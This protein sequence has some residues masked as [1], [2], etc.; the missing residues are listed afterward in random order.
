MEQRKPK[1]TLALV[2]LMNYMV[3]S[4]MIQPNNS[5]FEAKVKELNANSEFIIGHVLENGM[6][7]AG[8]IPDELKDVGIKASYQYSLAVKANL[9]LNTL[10]K[11]AYKVDLSQARCYKLSVP[12]LFSLS[13]EDHK[14]VLLKCSTATGDMPKPMPTMPDD[15]ESTITDF[16]RRQP[17]LEN[18]KP[19]RAKA[20]GGGSVSAST[21]MDPDILTAKVVAS[22]E[23]R[24]TRIQY[25]TRETIEIESELLKSYDVRET[26]EGNLKTIDTVEIRLNSEIT[27]NMF[28]LN[29]VDGATECRLM[30]KTDVL[31]RTMRI[32]INQELKEFDYNTIISVMNVYE[33]VGESIHILRKQNKFKKPYI[34]D[35]STYK[36]YA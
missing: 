33:D 36:V 27:E 2:G 15:P 8:D 19:V 12:E 20:T 17:S 29:F 13:E 35:N 22:E 21:K 6:F 4:G 1:S 7:V 18:T 31:G 5:L 9:L 23:A 14:S 11:N 3:G 10:G 30:I 28:P 26:K 24:R 16:Y 32:I 25:T 34:W